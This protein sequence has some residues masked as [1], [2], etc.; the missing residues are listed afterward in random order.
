MPSGFKREELRSRYDVRSM[1]E[2]IWHSYTGKKT[3]ETLSDFLSH[4][5]SSSS[6]LLNAGSGIYPIGAAGWTE[7]SVDLF[8]QP[9]LGRPNAVC[10][11]IE[12]LPFKSQSFGAVVCVG[13][14][15]AYCDPA[16]AIA[17]FARVLVPS[18]VLVCDFGSTRS[19]LRVLRASYGR[20]ADLV[21]DQYNGKPE[22]IWVYDPAYI[23]SILRSAGFTIRA[24]KGTHT[25]S[26]LARRVGLSS[27]K[28]AL[29][30]K[31]LDWLLLP[32]RFADLMT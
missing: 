27:D 12:S 31:Y 18:G 23:D 8:T 26:A 29:L 22:R 7:I 25:W 16:L 9:L 17:E 15:L 11:S 20:S 5:E 28:A 30:Q 19:F 32:T 2:D 1:D 13:E 3:S 4:N 21:V 24:Q 6:V 14:V 10:A